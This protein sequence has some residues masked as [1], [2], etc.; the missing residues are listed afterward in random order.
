MYFF[1]SSQIYTGRYRP[2]HA[3]ENSVVT[4]DDCLENIEVASS[5]AVNLSHWEECLK[6][7]QIESRCTTGGDYSRENGA[8]IMYL[9]L[10]LLGLMISPSSALSYVPFP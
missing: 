8:H 3:R 9:E 7:Q 2:P 4:K 6:R 1:L 5:V 10:G